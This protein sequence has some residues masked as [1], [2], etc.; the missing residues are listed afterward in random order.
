M[1]ALVAEPPSLVVLVG[2]EEKRGKEG[3]GVQ[4]FLLPLFL[5][6]AEGRKGEGIISA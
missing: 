1:S 5:R 2:G 6:P 4:Q 3:K